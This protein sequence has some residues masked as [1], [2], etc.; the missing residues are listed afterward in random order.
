MSGSDVRNQ[1][2]E[3][4][5]QPKPFSRR[6]AH[7]HFTH[8]QPLSTAPGCP[9][10]VDDQTSLQCQTARR[11]TEIRH[12]VTDA[13][14]LPAEFRFLIQALVPAPGGGERN[15]TDD[16]LLAKQALSRLS[17]TPVSE[18]REQKKENRRFGHLRFDFCHLTSVI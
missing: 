14:P 1:G 9:D 10:P 11:K 13:C 15:R 2:S 3:V 18:V 17:Y 8:T 6:N 5:R 4:G 12:Q 16:L 7:C